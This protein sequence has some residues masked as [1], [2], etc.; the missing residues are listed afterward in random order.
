MDFTGSGWF[1]SR[2]VSRLSQF[3][4]FPT[5][6]IEGVLL[7]RYKRF[8]ADVRIVGGET[9]TAHCPNTGS[10]L[11]C[12]EPGSRVWLLESANAA[13]KYPLS[14]EL[15]E[16]KGSVWVGI[17]TGRSNHLVREAIEDGVIAE[18]QG[19]ERIRPE[20]RYGLENSRIDLLLEGRGERCYVEVKNVTAAVD[21]GVALFPDAVSARGSKHLRELAAMVREGHRGVILYCVQRA[22]V[23]QVR[24]ADTIDPA[25]G[26]ALRDAMAQGVE[27]IAYR[28]DLNSDGI[29]LRHSLPVVVPDG[30]SSAD[31]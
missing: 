26:R 18:L 14:W 23:D 24:P 7:R 27:A 1:N 3:M 25:Y 28:A 21:D 15:V 5:P 2:S 8:L 10:M 6:L 31:G 12:N 29:T 9:V 22:D 30:F 4:K 13:R 17:N 19:Y 16:V 20:V 11:G